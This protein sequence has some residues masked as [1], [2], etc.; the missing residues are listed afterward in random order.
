MPFVKAMLSLEGL[1]VDN[2]EGL[3]LAQLRRLAIGLNEVVK[4]NT[5]YLLYEGVGFIGRFK[6]GWVLANPP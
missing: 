2:F 5:V 3:G 1:F 4:I 6:T